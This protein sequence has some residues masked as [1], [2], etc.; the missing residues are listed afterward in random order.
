MLTNR[1]QQIKVSVLF[2]ENLNHLVSSVEKLIPHSFIIKSQL[3]YL[4]DPL[5]AKLQLHEAIVLIY[6]SENYFCYSG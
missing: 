4:K 2:D 1:I 5:K 3:N 6:F